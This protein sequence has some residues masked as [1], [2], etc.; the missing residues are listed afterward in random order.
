MRAVTAAQV[1]KC[2]SVGVR[3]TNGGSTVLRE[4]QMRAKAL[5]CSYSAML[6]AIDYGDSSFWHAFSWESFVGEEEYVVRA[7]LI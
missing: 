6:N 1:L 4:K 7:G 5:G 3:R 2:S